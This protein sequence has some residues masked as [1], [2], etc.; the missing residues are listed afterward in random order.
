MTPYRTVALLARE[1]GLQV[2]TNALIGNGLIDLVHVF[3]HGTRPKAEGGGERP[4]LSRYRDAAGTHGLPLTV[5]DMPE[6]RDLGAHMPAG[7]VDLLVSV[8]WRALVGE[9]VLGRLGAGAINLHRGALPAYA[10][11]EPVRRALEAGEARVA[12]TAHHMTAEID[13]GAE[14]ARVWLDVGGI[15]AEWPAAERAERVKEMLVP[16]YA[17]LARTAIGAFARSLPA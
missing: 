7:D 4:E 8:S 15:A 14:I 1:P 10:G 5:L 12:I 13:A 9:D 17:P 2:L 6:A 16:L 11:A 3:T